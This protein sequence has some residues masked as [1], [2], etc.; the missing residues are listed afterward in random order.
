[1][2]FFDLFRRKPPEPALSI[3]N[4]G[5][6]R[7]H[8]YAMA[9]H[10]LRGVALEDPLFYLAVLASPDAGRFLADLFRSVSKHCAGR[11]ARPDFAAADLTVHC[12]KVGRFPCAVV[13][14]P[15][16]R[17][18]TEVFFTATVLLADPAE[19]TRDA[20]PPAA[21]YFTLEKG[22]TFEGPPRTV[23]CEWTAAGA[24]ANKGDGP[25]P[26]LA[27]FVAAVEGH[28]AHSL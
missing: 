9:H 17:A 28:V 23:L 26:E 19:V 1:M 4:L 8:H 15:P 12:V 21:R 3:E 10:A 16:P 14:F 24:H 27:A 22:F 25:V 5:E 6:P 18:T 7:C 2:G 13:A 20:P 11:E